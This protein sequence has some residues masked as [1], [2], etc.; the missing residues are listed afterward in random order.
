MNEM[1]KKLIKK[2]NVGFY[3]YYKTTM[4]LLSNGKECYNFFTHIEFSEKF[5]S[6]QE[7]KFITSSPTTINDDWKLMIGEE[8]LPVELFLPF[9]DEC[10]SGG[11]KNNGLEILL[12]STFPTPLKFVPSTDPTGG[13]YNLYIPIE[14]HLYGSN[15][16]GNYYLLEMFS[17]KEK[18]KS[19]F[20]DKDIEKISTCIENLKIGFKFN[21]LKDRIGNVLCKFNV[22]TIIDKPKS[23]GATR[24]ISVEFKRDP[25][26][27]EDHSYAVKIEQEFDKLTYDFRVFD[28]FDFNNI[29]DIPPNQFNNKIMLWD[30]TTGLILFSMILDYRVSVGYDSLILPPQWLISATTQSRKLYFEEN[31]E[32]IHFSNQTAIGDIYTFVEPYEIQK[33]RQREKDRFLKERL[34]LISY[35]SGNHKKAIMDIRNIINNSHLLWDLEEIMLLDPYLSVDDIINTAFYC[36]KKAISI[37]AVCCF[38]DIHNNSQTTEISNA[39]DYE[40]FKQTASDK[41]KRVLGENTDIKLEYRSVRSSKG[42]PFHDRYLI[43]RYSVNQYKVW[44]LGSSIN[45]IGNRHSIIQIVSTPSLIADVFE[46][47]W[48]DTNYDECIIFNNR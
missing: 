48:Y 40:C 3:N 5:D 37:R 34:E 44:S 42:K 6:E 46:N 2:G 20:S 29:I 11:F 38:S 47:I 14:Q 7:L 32:E 12:D 43:M 8:V 31:T 41:L 28:P 26:L 21:I 27:T 17:K 25:R 15:F 10:T 13:R 35:E 18:L 16:M 39:S 24:G 45:S 22:E 9:W 23:L 36:K 4:F 19:I 1:I 33:Y 30:K